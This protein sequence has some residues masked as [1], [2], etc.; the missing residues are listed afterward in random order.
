MIR[1]MLANRMFINGM[2]VLLLLIFSQSC[3]KQKGTASNVVVT[4]VSVHILKEKLDKNPKLL[5]LDVRTPGEHQ[6]DG[7]IR[8]AKRIPISKL[9][10]RIQE[11]DEYKN[12]EIYVICAVGQRSLAASQ[13]LKQKG[14]TRVFNVAGGMVD[15]KKNRYGVTR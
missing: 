2:A 4:N 10:R 13:Y 5:V 12:S 11:L 3:G 1:K 14:F 6:R 7:Y 15:W 9:S 8:G